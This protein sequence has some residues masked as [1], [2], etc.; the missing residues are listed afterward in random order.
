M[1]SLLIPKAGKIVRKDIVRYCLGQRTTHPLTINPWSENTYSPEERDLAMGKAAAWLLHSQDSMKDAGFGSYHLINKWSSSYVETT[2]YI[3]PTLLDYGILINNVEVVS[4]AIRSAE[5][6]KSIQKLSGGWQGECI[7]DNRPE[8]V[9]NTGQVVRGLISIFKYNGD[10]GMLDSAIKACN[11]LCEI[12]EEEGYWRKHA[13]RNVERVYDSY[14]DLPLLQMFEITGNEIYRQRALKNLYWIIEKKQHQ[15]GWFDDCDNTIKHNDMPILHTIG[16][17]IDGLLDCGILLND[18]ML[19]EA[20]RKSA[21]KLFEIFNSKKYLKGR[22]DR[23][24]NGSE[25]IIPTGCAQIA[26]VWLKLYRKTG[27]AQYLNASLKMNDLLIFIQDRIKNE[28]PDTKGAIPGSYPVWGKYEP[29]S[30]PNWATKFFMDSL[31]LE[32][33]CMEEALSK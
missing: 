21:D 32:K 14:V 13:F 23:D 20:A 28:H 2:G 25:F 16:Y 8:I 3:I 29:F 7:D 17:T 30:F 9:F 6:L 24:W 1:F 31:Y 19:I 15:N 11:W 4:K 26:I 27:N 33:K 18:N 12:Q 5:W 22:Y 10:R